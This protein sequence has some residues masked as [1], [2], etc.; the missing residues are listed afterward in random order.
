M[1][2]QNQYSTPIAWGILT[3]DTQDQALDRAGLKYGNKGREA[4]LAAIEMA[5]L[6]EQ[7]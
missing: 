1:A 3:P 2:L 6:L 5:G 7:L 4:A